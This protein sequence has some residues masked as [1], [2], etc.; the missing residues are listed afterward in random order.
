M[1]KTKNISNTDLLTEK[2]LSASSSQIPATSYTL[3]ESIQ[4]DCSYNW[5]PISGSSAE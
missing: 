1:S 5:V 3:C 2:Q 4:S